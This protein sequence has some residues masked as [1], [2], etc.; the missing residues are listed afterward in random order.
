MLTIN[1]LPESA[2]KSGPSSIEQLHRT[3][4]VLIAAAIMVAI[5]ILVFIPLSLR[6]QQLQQL[7]AK[8]EALKPKKAEVDEIQNFLRRLH[9]QED[10]FRGLGQE[11]QLWA[12]KLNILSN[13]VPDGVWFTELNLDLGKTLVLHG[14]AVGEGGAETGSVGHLVQSLKE[15]VEF[16][17][18]VKDIQIESIKRSQEKEVELVQFTITCALVEKSK[19]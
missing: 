16:S 6:R 4:L 7:N 5:P 14:S 11:Q 9:E 13:L 19:P 15:N 8:I 18:G 10:A 17:S 2:R 3:P 1:L 12:K